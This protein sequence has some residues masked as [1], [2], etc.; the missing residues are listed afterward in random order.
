MDIPADRTAAILEIY[1][2]VSSLVSPSSSSSS[3]ESALWVEA[4]PR[5][6]FVPPRATRSG[7]IG[8]PYLSP[9]SLVTSALR[10]ALL[11]AS[12]IANSSRIQSYVNGYLEKIQLVAPSES[13]SEGAREVQAS[14]SSNAHALS[15]SE[16]FGRHLFTLFPSAPTKAPLV[17]AVIGGFISTEKLRLIDYLLD[18]VNTI[19]ITGE[20]AIPFLAMGLTE[21]F[22]PGTEEIVPAESYTPDAVGVLMHF[23]APQY[24][25][26]VVTHRDSCALLRYVSKIDR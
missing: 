6:L 1:R 26:I 2:S 17:T 21:G 4:S 16:S 25:D 5:A 22:T 11:W 13:V 24:A 3:A 8:R 19:I 15:Y 14:A 23:K 12:V 7:K 9:N 10:E 18:T 20:L